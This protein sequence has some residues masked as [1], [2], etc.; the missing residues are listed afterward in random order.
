MVPWQHNE[1]T[2]V[3]RLQFGRAPADPLAARLRIAGLLA[4][5]ELRPP[6]LA[7]A[8]IVCIRKL[9]DPLPG[10]LRLD[11]YG[12]HPPPAWQ[13][14]VSAELARLTSQA[15][16][17]VRE[18]VPA[19]AECVLF[20]D[21]AEL[22]ACLARDWCAGEIRRHWWWQG[23]F[24]RQESARAVLSAWREAPAYLPGAWQYL[25]E[26][27]SAQAFAARLRADETRDLLQD[28]LRC[29][30][31]DELRVALD[32]A[33]TPSRVG[34]A[35]H[36]PAGQT[37]TNAPAGSAAAHRPSGV[38]T[39]APWQDWAPEAGH[40]ALTPAQQCLLGLALTLRR[41]P[42]VARTR[43]F[44]RAVQSWS[45]DVQQRP[46][47]AARTA[48]SA[49]VGQEQRMASQADGPA[50]VRAG[51]PQSL[52]TNNSAPRA[53]ELAPLAAKRHA[54][55]AAGGSD[56]HRAAANEASVVTSETKVAPRAMEVGCAA[57]AP[58]TLLNEAALLTDYGGLFYLLNLALYLELY[59]D[60]TTPAV[61][62]IPLGIWDFLA[63]LGERL[64]GT[65]LRRDPVWMLLAQL[66]GRDEGQ[67]PGAD[68]VLPEQW[69]APA[70]WLEPL[71]TD[72]Q[73]T[74]AMNAGRLR[75]C[76]PAQ[77]LV[78]DLPLADD[79][80]AQLRNELAA[81]A[82]LPAVAPANIH[83]ASGAEST[84]AKGLLAATTAP[85]TALQRWLDWLLPY[86]R[87]RLQRALRLA[88]AE[89]V[90]TTLCAHRARVFVTTT[91]LDVRLTLADLPVAL[92]WAGLDRDPGWIPATGRIIKFHF[93]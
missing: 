88:E 63:L 17:P 26:L 67:E 35:A 16:R 19:N 38:T 40:S 86:V 29:F 60:I 30:A 91:H 65:A 54:P 23:L 78:L 3:A 6:G 10:A 27:G 52:P 68:G 18:A 79:P 8:A 71:A 50:T 13:Q 41:A 46:A 33:A 81:Y 53:V 4:A 84:F 55:V 77:F 74:W 32:L 57:S 22:L 44:A 51:A 21:R 42:A 12:L 61:R 72:E 85:A 49:A 62:D 64:V 66:A 11:Q 75:V 25:V 87:V 24:P 15:A 5:S 82:P 34:V 28:L 39:I 58:N 14:A 89:A 9:R 80:A 7:P 69:R 59:G 76:H 90:G 45:S 43:A 47:A 70:A 2:T 48:P 1:T 92:R 83:C 36:A 31:L 20:A 37:E 73:W 56:D 93:E